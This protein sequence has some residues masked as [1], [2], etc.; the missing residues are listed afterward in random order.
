MMTS[1]ASSVFSWFATDFNRAEIILMTVCR[2][3]THHRIVVPK[4]PTRSTN[5]KVDIYY[6]TRPPG[7]S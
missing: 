1:Y 5:K 3:Q 4:T 7:T 6:R 2:N